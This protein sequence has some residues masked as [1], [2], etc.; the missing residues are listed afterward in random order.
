M[1]KENEVMKE[2]LVCP[3]CGTENVAFWKRVWYDANTEEVIDDY[4]DIENYYCNEGC[5]D[6]EPIT[7][8]EYKDK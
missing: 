6:V 5:C 2:K 3:E 4:S 8:Q 1:N 7:E